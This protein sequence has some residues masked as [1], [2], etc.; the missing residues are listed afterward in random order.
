[1]NK[2]KLYSSAVGMARGTTRFFWRGAVL[3]LVI[4]Q[5][6]FIDG[7]YASAIPET[8]GTTNVSST[9]GINGN[10]APAGTKPLDPEPNATGGKTAETNATNSIPN[11]TG[12][13]PAA[14]LIA[15]NQPLT[16]IGSGFRDKAS[17]NFSDAEGNV[18][19]GEVVRIEPEHLVVLASLGLAGQWKVT[20]QNPGSAASIPLRFQV[21]NAPLPGYPLRAGAFFSVLI[22]VTVFLCVL[23]RFILRNLRE[24]QVAQQ[25][26]FGDALSEEAAYQPKEVRH[27]GDVI[28]LASSSRLIAL[29]GLLGILMIVIGVGC[30]VMWNLFLFGTI[31]DL[32]QIRLFLYGAACLFA[33]YLANQLGGI[34]TPKAQPQAAETPSS[35]TITGIGPTSP[36]AAAGAQL[37]KVT[38]NGFKP[39]ATLA[40]TDPT[41]GTQVVNGRA[42]TS[43]FPTLIEANIVFDT[44]GTWK[45]VLQDPAIESSPAY[46]VTVSGPPKIEGTNPV[47]SSQNEQDLAIAGK[48]FVS[49]VTIS[50]TDPSGIQV[51]AAI[52]S[53]TSTS[54]KVKPVLK[55]PGKWQI[56]ATNPGNN[57][58]TAY[59]LN[60]N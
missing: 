1:M 27:K 20:V 25:W 18:Y 33:P 39:T 21:A 6:I 12:I 46:F 53:V 40:L 60:V 36:T 54:V 34:F 44:P 47:G 23:F 41:G 45:I 16:L 55:T 43:I 28:L 30:A 15:P 51:P 35:A 8:G 48:G 7:V 49:G 24:A 19:P 31:P 4:V 14:P 9:T 26:S 22:L 50:L 42:I 38:G 3:F 17:V 29:L 5:G 32:S 2:S 59:T 57:A 10:N 58:S 52:V 11:L 56:V 37:V 13:V